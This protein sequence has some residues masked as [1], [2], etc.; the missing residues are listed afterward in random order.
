MT[1][2]TKLFASMMIAFAI[3]ACSSTPEQ[4][5]APVEDVVPVEQLYN[6]AMAAVLAGEYETAAP[7]F[8]EV[9]RQHPYS[10]WAIQA[11][12]MSAYALYQ[13]NN[14]DDAIAALDR[15]IRLNPGNANAAYAHYLRGLSY[16][17]QIPDVGRDQLMTR[18]ALETFDILIKRF[19]ESKYTRDARLKVD[20]TRNHLAG[21]EMSVGRYYAERGQFLAAIN[22]FRTVVEQYDT[23][24]QV[25][26]ALHR[27]TELYLALG[28]TQEAQRT[29]AILSHNYPGSAWYVDSYTVVTTGKSTG[30][31]E[32]KSVVDR[33]WS[34]LLGLF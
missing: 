23:T 32:D 20:L 12:L 14:Y 2:Y 22:R 7:Q 16:Y 26:E 29:A 6:Q 5:I 21:K 18:L 8:D 4:E 19:P 34:G 17:E 13:D 10:V 31:D 25:P 28:L 15:F 1:T 27:L 24:E 33:V 30:E 11:Q 9:E 3:T